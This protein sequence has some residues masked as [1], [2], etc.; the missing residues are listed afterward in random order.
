MVLRTCAQFCAW[1]PF[2]VADCLW[3]RDQIR[4]DIC[5]EST[6]SVSTSFLDPCSG[7]WKLEFCLTNW[8]L[9]MA[10][11]SQLEQFKTAALHNDLERTFGS[12]RHTS[13]IGE[14]RLMGYF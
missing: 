12:L 9:H 4:F 8:F 13:H 3:C 6:F 11:T 5:K 10:N 1:G 2:L 7:I 14:E